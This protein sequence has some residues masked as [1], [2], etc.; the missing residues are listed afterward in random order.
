MY[1][2]SSWTVELRF[3]HVFLQI[4]YPIHRTKV[5]EMATYY[6]PPDEILTFD[7]ALQRQP[8]QVRNELLHGRESNFIMVLMVYLCFVAI[9][10]LFVGSAR[11]LGPWMT[12]AIVFGIWCYVHWERVCFY[13][14]FVRV[15]RVLMAWAIIVLV[16]RLA[17]LGNSV[18]KFCIGLLKSL[19]G[20]WDIMVGVVESVGPHVAFLLVA[21]WYD[22]IVWEGEGLRALTALVCALYQ[23]AHQQLCF[24][25]NGHR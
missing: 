14:G 19:E 16:S 21:G 23:F 6:F 4:S 18:E 9:W 2:D 15:R 13:M 8:P 20:G 7:Q 11:E 25:L 3:L 5:K 17:L 24:C 22:R 10:A 12:C 1:I